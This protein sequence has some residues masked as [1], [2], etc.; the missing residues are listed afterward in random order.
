MTARNP[1]QSNR[2]LVCTAGGLTVALAVWVVYSVFENPQLLPVKDFVEY[3]AAGA[4]AARGGNPY[5]AEELLPYQRQAGH[6]AQHDRAVMMWNPPWAL[7]LVVPLGLLPPRTAHLAWLGGQLLAVVVSALWL[8]RVYGGARHHSGLA[9]AVAVF[10]APFFLLMWYGQI[11]ALCLLGLAGFLAAHQRG[12]P[13][14]AGAFAALTALKPH[15]LFAFGVALL[16]DAVVTRRGR[17]A[18]ATGAAVLVAA[19]L[20]VWLAHPDVYA[21]Y[22]DALTR[23]A[24]TTAQVQPKD[25]KLPLLSYWL[26]IATAPQSF[27][28]QFLPTLLAA[29]GVA[30]YWFVRRDRW[31]WPVELPRLVFVSVLLAAYGAWIFDLVVLL[32]PVLQATVWLTRQATTAAGLMLGAAY[33]MLNVGTVAVPLGLI[34]TASDPAQREFGLHHFIYFSP[35]ILLLYLAAGRLTR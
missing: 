26:R 7:V 18:L 2:V 6:D 33:I 3:Y 11:G 21:H 23:D 1:D 30:G 35:A 13:A 19:A 8:W 4:V 5:D 17:I 14:T 28:V 34:A 15:L 29:V 20:L 10:F 22:R 31:D 24:S 9:V 25:W 12:R 16:L 32:V 27:G